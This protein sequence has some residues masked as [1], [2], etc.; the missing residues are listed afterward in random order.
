MP[1]SPPVEC[2]ETCESTTLQALLVLLPG[3]YIT[4]TA[5]AGGLRSHE[6]LQRAANICWLGRGYVYV[7]M[8]HTTSSASP[9][10]LMTFRLE[11]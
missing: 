5:A 2:Q 6:H 1:T 11:P 8:M 9:C 3:T 4:G 10:I 7:D